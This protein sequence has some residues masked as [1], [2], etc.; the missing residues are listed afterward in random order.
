[1]GFFIFSMSA[2]SLNK[3]NDYFVGQFNA[4]ASPCEVLV[5]T[6]NRQYASKLV[7]IARNEAL[8][9]ENKFSRYRTDNIIH[10]INHSTGQPVSVDE[11]TANLLDY[12]QQCYQLC[13]GLFDVTSGVLRQIWHFNGSDKLAKQS[14]VDKLLSNIGWDKVTWNRPNIILPEGMEIDFGGIGKEYAVDQSCQLIM[15]TSDT[16]CLINYGGDIRVTTTRSNGQPW[17]IGV[18]DPNQ[19][20]TLKTK[21]PY[22]KLSRGAIATSGD[23]RKYL[24][25]DGIRYSHVLNPKTGWP[26]A[27]APR[28]VTVAANTCTEAGILA[29][30]A[31]LH[32]QHAEDFL[33]SEQVT[34]WCEW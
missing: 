24:L 30:L 34:Y 5:E 2:I 13:D 12:A 33:K 4:M 21:S 9:I 8:R 29:T 11:E 7:E 18:E 19:L 31:L 3:Q 17:I 20:D 25:K 15:K 32:E 26:V 23:T 10:Q 27:N 1:M 6:E 14:Q 28:S 16:S 22:I